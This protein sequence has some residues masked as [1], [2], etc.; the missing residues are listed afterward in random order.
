MKLTAA[1]TRA[2]IPNGRFTGPGSPVGGI[3]MIPDEE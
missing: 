2:R 3:S 1:V